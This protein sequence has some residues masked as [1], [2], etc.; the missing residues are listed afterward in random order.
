MSK[1]LICLLVI[2]LACLMPVAAGDVFHSRGYTA[3]A[4]FEHWDWETSDFGVATIFFMNVSEYREQ[5]PPGKARTVPRLV[6]SAH[7]IDSQGETLFNFYGEKELGPED[8]Q[9]DRTLNL[10]H[11]ATKG[12]VFWADRLFSF[13]VNLTLKAIGPVSGENRHEHISGFG[14][15]VNYH[16]TGKSRDAEAVGTVFFNGED[17]NFTPDPGT[18][19]LISSKVMHLT[20]E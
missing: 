17:R 8:F 14:P 6:F 19:Q 15:R 10:A 4:S 5:A 1:T 16:W 20:V 12:E 18:G 9:I 7:R 2:N 11:I 13:E 3:T